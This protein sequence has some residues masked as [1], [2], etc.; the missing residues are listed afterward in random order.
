M[1]LNNTA[2]Q[3]ATSSRV[4][5]GWMIEA[6]AD[7]VRFAAEHG[8]CLLR[9]HA[10][11][12]LADPFALARMDDPT[13][14]IVAVEDPWSGMSLVGVG[15]EPAPSGD[16]ALAW[17]ARSR[18]LVVERAAPGGEERAVPVALAALPFDPG[19]AP[20]GPW[21]RWPSAVVRVPS[22]LA[23]A[24]GGVSGVVHQVRVGEG[25]A[26]AHV[27]AA[28]VAR[29]DEVERRV[30]RA[31]GVHAVWTRPTGAACQGLLSRTDETRDAWCA[32]VERALATL[33]AGP[34]R[35]V[36]PARS[37]RFLPPRGYRFD[38]GATL[39]ALRRR[40]PGALCFAVSQPWG[41]FVGASPE[42]LLRVD[43][44]RVESRPLAGTAARGADPERDAE[45]ERALLDSS[46]DRRE[47]RLVVDAIRAALEPACEELDV[48]GAPHVARLPTMLHLETPIR[49]RLRAGEGAL[50][51]LG[52]LHPT[53]AI[54]GA[55]AAP[56]M[57]WLRREE[58]VPRGLFGGPVGWVGRDGA[59]FALGIRSALVTPGEA[60]AWAGA[61]IVRGSDP[62]AEWRETH[63]K[64][65]VVRDALAVRRSRG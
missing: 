19:A 33:V 34:L 16:E 64:L 11:L 55:P 48:P 49:G 26:A 1:P 20:A 29:W 14:S 52:R 60:V 2:P 59:T 62:E 3:I 31:S 5:E 10:P 36:V 45:L 21:E 30:A 24:A 65:A 39:H 28:L 63:L 54:G 22:I 58:P 35:K 61:G 15:E 7:A 25:D 43:G 47:H 56:A 51:V 23:W 42:L 37:V 17:C 38:L 9:V 27:A 18:E 8:A 6:A 57:E 32:R 50:A 46:K 40:N 41:C 12:A 44:D 13:A 53:P 4:P